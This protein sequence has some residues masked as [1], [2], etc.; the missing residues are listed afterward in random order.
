MG[1]RYQDDT[2][3]GH[4]KH[5]DERNRHDALICLSQQ[6]QSVPVLALNQPTY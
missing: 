3:Q 5:G 6:A 1:L 4:G 2:P